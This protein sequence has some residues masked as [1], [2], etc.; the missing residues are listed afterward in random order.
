M[1][2]VESEPDVDITHKKLIGSAMR[3]FL[4]LLLLV[5]ATARGELPNILWITSEDNSPMLGCYGD[6]VARTPNI[7]QFAERGV[8]FLN[9]FSN[10]AVC[11]P[12]RQTLITGMY[13][14]SIGGQHMRSKAV[15]PPGVEFFPKYLRDEGY[16]TTNNS[17]TDYNGGP[18]D[19]KAAMSAA[20]DESSNKAHWRKR[21]EGAPF[22]SVFNITDTHESRLFPGKWKNRETKTD[23]ASVV[24]PGFIPELPETRRDMA[25]YYDCLENMDNRVGQILAE[26]EED[27]LADETIVFYFSDHGGSMPRGK[28]F[29]YDSGTHVPLIVH[30]PEKWAKYRLSAVGGT[31]DQLVSFVDLSATVLSLAGIEAPAYMQGAAFLGDL[32]KEGRSYAHTFRGRRGERYDIVRGV[33][34]KDYLYVRNYTPHLPVMQFNAYSFAIPAYQVWQD[35]V[36]LG[37]STP[38]QARWFKPKAKEELYRVADD[39]DNIQNRADDPKLA[40]VL[41]KHR[42]ENE[43]HLLAIRDSVFYTEGL[44]GREFSAYQNDES[45]PLEK[46]ITLND[47]G[48]L[49]DFLEVINDSN[50]CLRYWAVTACLLLGDGAEAAI[51]KLLPLLEDDDP[52]VRIQAARTLAGLGKTDEAIPVLRKALRSKSEYEPLQALL[53]IDECNLLSV[54]PSLREDIEQMKKGSYSGRVIEKLLRAEANQSR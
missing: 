12:A 1:P 10:A 45:Y 49:E 21:P 16:Y 51:P 38:E 47:S 40:E 28:S 4:V 14:T 44:A 33:R 30:M 6:P 35:A 43:R 3:F 39:P 24:L 34:S 31:T 23:P 26:L 7:D 19:S 29:A 27:G 9:C 37:Q 25:R 15:Y 50:V 54:D 46:L 17:K 2:K 36:K 11:A 8:R 48:K 18:A 5:S 52:V 42:A 32:K 20:W 22:F 41:A 13:A 53:A